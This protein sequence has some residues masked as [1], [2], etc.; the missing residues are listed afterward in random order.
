MFMSQQYILFFF[1]LRLCSFSVSYTFRHGKFVN[2]TYNGEWYNAKMDGVGKL[3]GPKEPQDRSGQDGRQE[4]NRGPAR[5]EKFTYHGEF[6]E[7][8]RH[9]WATFTP[10]FV[11]TSHNILRCTTCISY[12]DIISKNIVNLM[13]NPYF[14]TEIQWAI[15]ILWAWIQWGILILWAWI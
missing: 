10:L 7:N 8:Q 15:L 3:T 4:T 1:K 14:L 12:L 13:S 11:R 6:R 2:C 9:G 5:L